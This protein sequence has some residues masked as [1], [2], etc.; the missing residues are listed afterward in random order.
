MGLS[1]NNN[2]NNNN[3]NST[4]IYKE[5]CVNMSLNLYRLHDMARY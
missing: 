4:T 1:Y 2:N 3:N 5:H